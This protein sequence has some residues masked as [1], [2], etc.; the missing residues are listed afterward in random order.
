MEDVV[1]RTVKLEELLIW[2]ENPRYDVIDSKEL[3]NKT[4]IELIDILWKEVGKDK[5]L[6]LATSINTNGFRESRPPLT[7]FE[8]GLYKVYDGNRRVACAKLIARQD[9]RLQFEIYNIT[10]QTDVSV[11]VVSR[12]QALD[13][14]DEIHAGT[15]AGRVIPWNAYMRDKSLNS[16]GKQPKYP[17]AFPF[18]VACGIK[19]KSDFENTKYSDID[20]IL[21]NTK[22]VKILTNITDNKSIQFFLLKK[23]K[24]Q[25]KKAWSRY[26]PVINSSNEEQE[27]FKEK[28]TNIYKLY[29]GPNFS[30]NSD[31]T[32]EPEPTPNPNHNPKL[33][34]G[35]YANPKLSQQPQPEPEHISNPQKNRDLF[36]NSKTIVPRSFFLAS[37]ERKINLIISEL[38]T[39][40]KE[41][42]EIACSLLLRALIEQSAKVFLVSN[43]EYTQETVVD[44]TFQPSISIAANLLQKKGL[45]Q[46][47]DVIAIKRETESKG[48]RGTFNSYVHSPYSIPTAGNL[49]S[50]FQ[51]YLNF[52]NLCLQN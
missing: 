49:D 24:T 7:V 40:E 17:K 2:S 5:M 18:A 28:V 27:A 22:M 29:Y 37:R 13:E 6:P 1:I 30:S 3:N 50:I 23:F 52:I 12:E 10:Q 41:G 15:N 32:L 31:S 21:S 46:K 38:K 20:S 47:N 39:I 48:V 25:N 34:S 9:S 11:V 51:A 8:Q 44:L 45:M 4:E 33:D 26:L 35:S 42:H 43:K 19:N 14:M 16:R 36:K